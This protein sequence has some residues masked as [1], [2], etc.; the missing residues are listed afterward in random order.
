MKVGE[1]MGRT[2]GGERGGGGGIVKGKD[3]GWGGGR[4]GG[5]RVVR[6]KEGG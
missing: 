3:G 2:L 5:G 6:R 4:G 1:G